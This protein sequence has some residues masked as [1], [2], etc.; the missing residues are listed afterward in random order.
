MI[1]FTAWGLICGDGWSILEAAVVC[2]QLE[3][4]YASDSVQTDFFGGNRSS[5]TLSG[6]QCHGNEVSLEHC[7]H[8]ETKSVECP[9]RE[10]N[11][12]AV[13]CSPGN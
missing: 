5:M 9:G 6:V 12:A 7:I 10:E 13:I 8:T 1:N 4:G 11:I 2:R 3:L